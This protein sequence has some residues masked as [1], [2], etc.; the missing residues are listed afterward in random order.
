MSQARCTNESIQCWCLAII[1]FKLH[2][3]FPFC[4]SHFNQFSVIYRNREQARLT[5]TMYFPRHIPSIRGAYE[6]WKSKIQ[7]EKGTRNKSIETESWVGVWGW[8]D[9]ERK[10]SSVRFLLYILLFSKWKVS[11]L[12]LSLQD[13]LTLP[14]IRDDLVSETKN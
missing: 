4:W 3:K 1:L 12:F 9:N 5:K 14:I 7:A 11:M 2:Y 10:W 6:H 8:E 13:N